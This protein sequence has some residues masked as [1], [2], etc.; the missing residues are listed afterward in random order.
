MWF[1]FGLVGLTG[2]AGA[3]WVI[4]RVPLP[5]E[6]PQAESTIVYDGA[7]NQ[8]AVF[9]GDENRFPV[10]LDQVPQITRDAVLSAEDRNF[11]SHTGIDPI[12]I[13]RATWA[14]I[15]TGA[16]Q[17]GGSTITQQ[18][19]KNAYPRASKRSIVQKLREAVIAV[20]LEQKHSKA[21]ILER[22][23]NT[24]YF[25]RGAYGISAAA[26]AYYGMEVGQ[27]GLRE[28]SYL[29][30]L[31][32]S[33]S[34]SDVADDPDRADTLRSIVLR[35]LVRD[36]KITPQQ[37]AEVEAIPLQ[38]YVI[39]PKPT[40]D[41]QITATNV[42]GVEY[43]VEYVR[44]QLLSR[45]GYNLDQ[46]LRGGL[47]VHTTLDPRVQNLAYESV[48][49]TLDGPKDP[50]GAL[51]SV[52]NEG[53]VVAMVGGKDWAQSRVNLAVG[54][55]GGGSGRQ[56]GSAFK[57]FVLAAGIRDGMSV[58][59]TFPAPAKLLI[60]NAMGGPWEVSNFE[61]A[62]YGSANL[63]DATVNSVNTVYAQLVMNV[64]PGKVVDMAKALGI[65]SDLKALPAI[66]L[67]SQE[68][69]VLEMAGAYLTFA[70]E[71]MRVD[72]RVVAKIT[73]DD[74]VLL[75]DRPERTRVLDRDK[76]NIVNYVLHEVVAR[77]SGKAAQLNAGPACG[78][79]GTSEDY[80]DAW[81]VGYNNRLTTA[82]WMGYPSSRS[83]MLG[84][85]GVAKVNGGSL[86]A[87]IWKRFMSRA[88]DAECEYP[89]PSGFGPPSA[90]R[91][92]DFEEKPT[93]ATTSPPR[94]TT[95]TTT[96]AAPEP[97]T[98]PRD[99]E[100]P[101]QPTPTVAPDPP[102]TTPQPLT[103]PMSRRTP[104]ISIPSDPRLP[105]R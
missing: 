95:P 60:R 57:P 16:Y 48:Y 80:G 78:K 41:T 74:N 104:N 69:S 98:P 92:V 94:V 7:G 37:M 3:A 12:G 52:D 45:Y 55:D 18:Y 86:P 25:G 6:V 58:Q 71:G 39:P 75:D 81:F 30:G 87:L 73:V 50:A 65:K 89:V 103:P 51:V 62:A 63:I 88:A 66:A 21:E 36:R 68:V 5:P 44:Q 11:F 70:R 49:N 67:G 35:A 33:P 53:R 14:D 101:V 34:A 105:R 47:R 38:S 19:V 54:T 91:Q 102:A 42:K 8:L 29:I 9:H 43:Y 77:G 20:K 23:L 56:G 26:K 1:L 83:P 90:A 93:S 76:A 4:T 27:L 10:K 28:S 46:V 85:Q 82:V 79:T 97:T 99:E 96:R 22:Y 24:V 15:R 72:P 17:Q 100:E 31:I 40:P 2:L 59:T 64:G 32:R 84:V 61:D 13:A